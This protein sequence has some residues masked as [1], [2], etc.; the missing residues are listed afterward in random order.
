VARLFAGNG[1]APGAAN[2]LGRVIDEATGTRGLLALRSAALD[3][4]IRDLRGRIDA[5]QRA[6][7]AFERDL[8]RQFA[9]LETL[10]ASLESQASFLR[11]ALGGT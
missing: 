4:R 3:D 5:G 1:V 11:S 6:V 8:R 10:V 2:T 7:D 9:A